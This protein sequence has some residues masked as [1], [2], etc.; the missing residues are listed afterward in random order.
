MNKLFF[1]ITIVLILTVTSCKKE[2]NNPD[3]KQEEVTGKPPSSPPPPASILQWQKCIGSS[4]DDFGTAVAKATDGYFVAGYTT[5]ING[6]R[7]AIVSKINLDGT[8]V[9]WQKT[10]GGANSDEA[11]GVVSTGDG[12]C[13]IGGQTNSIDGD[14]NSNHGGG[15]VLLAKLSA[16]GTIEWTKALGGSGYDRAWAL[17]NTIDGGFAIAGQT[18]SNDGDLSSIPSLNNNG[19][20][21]LIKLDNAGNIEWQKT[22]AFDGAKDDVG[23]SIAQSSDGGYIIAGRTLSIDNNA[24]ICV[25][26]VNSTGNVNWT[27]TIGSSGGGGDVAFGVTTSMAND[28]YV[29]TG[30]LGAYNLMAEKLDNDGTVVWQKIFAGSTSGGIMGRAILST[31]QGYIITGQTSSKNGDIIAS[32]GDID[33]FILRLDLS[34]SKI[35]TNGVNVLGGKNSDAGKAVITATDAGYIAVGNTSSNNGDVS[36]NHGGSDMWVVKFDF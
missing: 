30:Y 26:N 16:S 3:L 31:N 7:N 5:D 2:I 17:I 21:W 12:G 6:N 14:L 20:V 4:T 8:I 35:S 9:D 34:G 36:G 29:V 13:L 1:L 32:K 19:R 10:V 11:A 24:D 27:K 15:D 25:V 22:F 18:T 23:Y 33:M 28:G